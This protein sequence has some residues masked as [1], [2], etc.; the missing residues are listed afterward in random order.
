[1][2]RDQQIVH[3]AQSRIDRAYLEALDVEALADLA[4]ELV[5]DAELLSAQGREEAAS[6]VMDAVEALIGTLEEELADDDAEDRRMW[7][8]DASRL[9]ASPAVEAPFVD[10]R[11]PDDTVVLRSLLAGRRP[12]RC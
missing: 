3:I 1:M 8:E 10:E 11:A 12:T 7:M 5:Q 6:G 2:T 9:G 4:E